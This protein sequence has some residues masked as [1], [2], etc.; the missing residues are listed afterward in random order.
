MM[1]RVPPT[2]N[3]QGRSTTTRMTMIGIQGHIRISRRQD[4]TLSYQKKKMSQANQSR[5]RTV[6]LTKIP[7]SM[8]TLCSEV[9]EGPMRKYVKP[10]EKK[11]V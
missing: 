3:V 10:K 8:N 7:S 5:T 6:A 4:D 9:P 1:S 2:K 11:I